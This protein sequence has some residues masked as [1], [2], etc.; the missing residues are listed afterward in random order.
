MLI[1]LFAF[2]FTALVV[3]SNFGSGL[4]AAVSVS[5]GPQSQIVQ[6]GTPI[7][8]SV[9][10]TGAQSYQWYKDGQP[11]EG[12]TGATLTIPAATTTDTGRFQVELSDGVNRFKLAPAVVVVRP[13]A[14]DPAAFVLNLNQP[15]PTDDKQ[16][17]IEG[18]NRVKAYL[19]GAPRPTIVEG[20]KL[21]GKAWDF[22]AT[23]ACIV[24]KASPSTKLLGDVA[25]STG[26]SFTAWVAGKPASRFHRFTTLVD[27]QTNDSGGFSFPIGD[28]A[29][30]VPIYLDTP[31]QMVDGDWHFLT[32][33]IDFTTDDRNIA[34]YL[35]GKPNLVMSRKVDQSFIPGDFNIGARGPNNG[36]CHFKI[37]QVAA[38]H[39]ALSAAEVATLFQSGTVTNYA[40][41][42]IARTD[43]NRLA[44]PDSHVQLL[45]AVMS[46]NPTQQ[47]TGT[48]SAVS[49]PAPVALSNPTSLTG[50]ATFTKPGKY[51]LRFTVNSGTDSIARDLPVEVVENQPPVPM[52]SV[53]PK[54]VSI[55]PA[56]VELVGG[57]LD[58]GLPEVPGHVTFHWEQVSG[59]GAAV[60]AHPDDVRTTVTLPQ[61]APGD[62]VFKLTANDGALSASTT[63]TASVVANLPPTAFAFC[64][65][66]IIDYSAT[67]ANSF[68]LECKA[69]DDH[70][71]VSPG[72]LSYAW[73]QVS[74]VAGQPKITFD[75]VSA[76][77]TTITVPAPGVYQV[78]VTVSDGQLSTTSDVW[79]K[80]VGPEV[81]RYLKSP[82]YVRVFSQTP[83]PFVHP[84]IFF[85]DEDRPD[86]LKKAKTDPL[87]MAAIQQMKQNIAQSLD[88]PKSVFGRVY[89]Q[90]KRGDT[91]LDF[92][93]V[94]PTGK[95]DG[96]V[97]GGLKDFYSIMAAK[98]Y[99]TWL[100]PDPA[101]C[102]EVA[103][104][105]AT[106]ARCHTA[107]KVPHDGLHHDVFVD[108]ALC[109]DLSYNWMTEDERATTRDL[110]AYE[111]KGRKTPFSDGIDADISTNW[112]DAHDYAILLQT[113]LE[114]EPGYD[115]ATTAYNEEAL[116]IFITKWGA[117]REGFNREGP[118]YFSLGMG[119]GSLAAYALSRRG[120][121]LAV[122]TNLSQCTLEHFYY[123]SPDTKFMW[124][125]GDAETWGGGPLYAVLKSFY[126]TDPMVDFNFRSSQTEVPIV[127]NQ[128]LTAAIFGENPLPGNDTPG[129]VA[130]AKNLALDV[131]SPQR[132]MAVARS[133]WTPDAVRLDFDCRFD[134]FN[135]GH[136]KTNRNSFYLYSHQRAWVTDA[137]YHSV[138]ND[139][140]SC[141]LIDGVGEAGC[142]LKPAWPSLPAKFLESISTPNFAL[143]SG[144]AK[145]AYDHRWGTP[146]VGTS[147]YG[148]Q[149]H[150]VPSE[151]RWCDFFPA[152]WEPPV[153]VHGTNAWLGDFMH[154]DPDAYNP[155]QKAFRTVILA[156]G[157]QPYVL[158]MDDIQKDS[159]PHSYL[160]SANSNEGG[161]DLE[162]KPGNSL[163]E[164]V[165]FR[166][167]DAGAP[168][169]P[170]LLVRVLQGD[171]TATPVSLQTE[172][173]GDVPASRI[174]I[175]RDNTVAPNFK[176]LLFPHLAN[177]PV[178]ETHL[179]PGKLTVLFPGGTQDV[180][181]LETDAAG[182]TL[183]TSFTRNGGTP[184]TIAL[185]KMAPAV[186]NEKTTDEQ[187]CATVTYTATA[188]DSAGQSV[189]VLCQPLSGSH[190]R[191]GVTP[192]L[193]TAVDSEG[194]VSI[195]RLPVEVQ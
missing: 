62:F 1:R 39:K 90:M 11:L 149:D 45:A 172:P 55:L 50:I 78:R 103:K 66:P 161:S 25:H 195:A 144:D 61:S 71:P 151:H 152:G 189:P 92:W 14:G 181:A 117:N 64:K 176:V 48:W 137:G 32:I 21:L 42:V 150:G 93:A 81:S 153:A 44:L 94:C 157:P 3:L 6:A 134:C 99:L 194:R 34:V 190:L 179:E 106:F 43:K 175:Q 33:S 127:K 114:G 120:E 180:W 40:P 146:K 102:R 20:P 84:R 72:A 96:Q 73:T 19:V 107:A 60:I 118:G 159:A 125:H 75:S 2:R 128:P 156:R 56:Q 113:A 79:V 170:E 46:V 142:Q 80:A 132:G 119:T 83:P 171:G 47:I 85:T 31:K 68:V 24:V 58:D 133:S 112:R 135:I 108:L 111:S 188:T 192:I 162:I 95:A 91:S 74:D 51:L 70:L 193:C 67:G 155:V 9:V 101:T 37:A 136:M 41:V 109:Y 30:T 23:D 52:A 5:A 167:A 126:P 182:R 183:V 147:S 105:V 166:Q 59:P 53:Y 122:T 138:S 145:D 87:V 35:D 10:A 165:Y 154:V 8:L 57:A 129:G 63:V 168:N 36:G 178:P 22:S 169:A 174:C 13:D 12:A 187:P 130:K 143:F 98:C 89:A 173:V 65:R 54:A 139:L 115:P 177:E 76:A 164:A 17:L 186:A 28:P 16:P 141:V 88:N 26:F 29:K 18:A 184:P 116:K 4:H 160:W 131:Y 123:I 148:N 124:G 104:V 27:A 185:P 77:S 15:L 7:T 69:S 82:D 191:K 140:H 100:E 158:V 121:N 38:Y 97:S 163:T 49:G 110:L 86:L